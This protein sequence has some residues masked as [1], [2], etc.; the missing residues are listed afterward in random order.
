MHKYINLS[1]QYGF[2]DKQKMNY[3]SVQQV[4]AEMDRL[5]IWQT[6]IEFPGGSNTVFRAQK[7]LEDLE[8]IPDWQER[9]IP[10]FALDVSVIFQRGGVEKLKQFLRTY[11]PSCVSLR[12]KDNKFRLR[13]ADMVLDQIQD[14]CSVVFV[15]KAQMNG[16]CAS[17]DIVYLA[18]RYP[19]LHFVIR[20]V[21]YSGYPFVVDVMHR[22]ENIYVDNSVLHTR[23]ALE[24]FC[25][26]F[27]ENRVLFSTE[28]RSYSGASMAA[29]TFCDLSE[30][31]KNK[32][33]YE[34]FI[35]LF[36]EESRKVLT[37]N[38]K[39]IPSQVKN[40]FWKPFVE[41]GIAPDVEIFDIHC[42]MGTTGSDWYLMDCDFESQIGAFEE[43]MA[44]LHVLKTV[45]SV[46]GRPDLIQANCDMEKAVGEKKGRFLGYVRYNPNYTDGFTDEYLDERFRSGYYVGLKT[47]PGYMGV[48]IR[49]EKY[50]KM[51]RYAN[52]HH[53]P[54][55][56]H[57]WDGKDP[58]SPWKCAEAAEKWPNAKI[59]L[60]HTGGAAAGRKECEA[61]AQDPR[62]NNVYFETCGSWG[63]GP[64][65]KTLEKIDYHR[66]VYGTDACL[67]NMAWEMGRLLSMDISDEQL[68]AILGGNAKRIFGF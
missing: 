7:L 43:D 20:R 30:E 41:Q 64:W 12:P 14:L 63:G 50:E 51:F 62:Y 47:L 45:A 10:S 18:Q 2:N 49:D 34:N 65:E 61:I 26:M 67:H 19:K 42:H 1:A 25:G 57:T 3:D 28:S 44:K 54:V 29:L 39:A 68:T 23:K 60:G 15:D 35:A 40:R 59:I 4:L 56:I 8:Q 22:A 17:D 27:G 5:G 16:D 38:L 58:G 6:V 31:A 53:L 21:G 9:L 48:D 33:R 11:R 24:L 36:D 46:S 66:V 37:K 55:L 13:M 52:E 32:I